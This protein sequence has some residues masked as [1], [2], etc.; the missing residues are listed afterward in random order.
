MATESDQSYQKIQALVKEKPELSSTVSAKLASL[1]EELKVDD[2]STVAKTN[3]DQLNFGF[4]KYKKDV[5]DTHTELTEKLKTGQWPKFMVIACADSRVDPSLVLGFKPGDA[6]T[7]RNVA[8]MVPPFEKEGY[9]SI[10]S[11][12]EYAV[13]HLKVDHIL[14]VGHSACGGI[15]ALV[16][17]TPDDGKYKTTFIEKWVEIGKPARAEVK[18]KSPQGETA[19]LCKTCEKTSVQNSLKN[20]LTY[21]FVVEAATQKKVS[22][23]GGYYDFINGSFETWD[24]DVPA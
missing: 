2:K 22:L 23:H 5:Y 11:A 21:P 18:A 7:I 14:I 8:N 24:F 4:L 15:G 13:L 9:P 1:L 12:L 10:G 19:D 16:K 3:F 6:F 17:M 20:L